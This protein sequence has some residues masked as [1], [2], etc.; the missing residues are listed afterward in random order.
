MSEQRPSSIKRFSQDIA[1]SDHTQTDISRSQ[2]AGVL[3]VCEQRP[4]SGSQVGSHL[5]LIESCTTQ[6]EAQGPSRTCNESKED[7][8][9]HRRWEPSLGVREQRP[10]T[11][12][13]LST[14]PRRARSTHTQTCFRIT[15]G[16]DTWCARTATLQCFRGGLI[17]EAHRRLYHSA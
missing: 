7:E 13:R 17:F 15:G 4:S 9:D 12:P 10:S 11:P 5:R 8:E 1:S 2:A 14:P 6:L 16:G 3:G